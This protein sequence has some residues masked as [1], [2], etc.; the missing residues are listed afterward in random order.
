MSFIFRHIFKIIQDRLSSSFMKDFLGNFL[1]L[2]VIHRFKSSI[3][4]FSNIDDAINFSYSFN[5]LEVSIK[6]YQIKEELSK[7]LQV[8]DKVKPKILVEIGTA[9]GGTLFLF[10]RITDP[11]AIIIS[12]DLPE[13]PY[14]KGYSE[15]KINLYKS[16]I[17]DNQR[18]YFI[19]ANSHEPNTLKKIKK[20]LVNMKIDFLFLD[21]DH[22][23]PG[24]KADF[25]MYS[26]L[27]KKGG[28]I[29]FHDIVKHDA[30][31]DPSAAIEID[32]FWKDI[33]DNYKNHEIIKNV[34][35]GWAGI[36]IIYK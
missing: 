26:P 35:Q 11:E 17:R 9:T 18:I 31:H 33:K 36:G 15:W 23:Y 20:I 27:V 10:T 7:L 8:L 28:I 21:G 25:D 29:A 13:G 2:F 22:T 3:D 5:Y 16:F 32:R 14:G 24:V 12:I 4:R 34:K 19:R 1:N 6:P 30:F